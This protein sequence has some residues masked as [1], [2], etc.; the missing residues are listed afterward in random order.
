MKRLICLYAFVLSFIFLLLQSAFA[1]APPL[2]WQKTFGGT[3]GDYGYSVQQTSDGGYIITGETWSYGAGFGDVHLIKTDP[4]G[5]S[6][7]Q[8]T[9]GGSDIE[10]GNS[11]QQTSDGGYIIAGSSGPY[12]AGDPNVYLIKAD[13]N[14][15]S[16]WQKTFG[17]SNHDG[18]GSVQ[19]T[20]NGGYIIAGGTMSYGAGWSDVYL[21][22][23]DPNGDI[24]WQKTFGG[25][26]NDYSSSVHETSDGGFIIAGYTS[27]YG[28]G[29]SDVYLI[30][31]EPNGNSMW[32]KTFGGSDEDSGNS[33]QQTSDGGYIIAGSAGLVPLYVPADVYLIKTD[34]NGNS[35]WQKTFG[36]SNDDGGGSVQ[37]TSDGGYIIAGTTDSYGAGQAD[38]YLI[39][40]DPNGSGRS[41]QQTSDGG[42]IIAGYT[43]SFGAEMADVYL[44]KTCSDGTLSADFNCNGT[45]YYEDLEILLTQWLQPPGILS[46]DI[47]PEP[48]DGI[49]N[50]FD[51]AALANDWLQSTIP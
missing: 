39:K 13:P 33:V 24:E 32:E 34:P 10:Y 1:G 37:Q 41:G 31:T 3:D 7:W 16:Q 20:S 21:I 12:F 17:G 11:V 8:K 6:Q 22:K 40:T 27:S 15:D 49:V 26:G 18:G 2:K 25:S 46:A 9:F 28:A 45:V 48:G 5:N 30:K 43:W 35:Q 44:I 19:Q 4:N 42:Y 38:V 23:T 14:G 29:G 47:Y 50:G 36:G 51:F